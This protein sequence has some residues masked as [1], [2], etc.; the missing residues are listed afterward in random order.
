MGKYANTPFLRFT[1][2]VVAAI[3]IALNLMLAWSLI[4]SRV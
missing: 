1:L 2:W 3:V 4:L